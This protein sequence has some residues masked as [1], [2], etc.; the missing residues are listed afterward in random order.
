MDGN[1]LEPQFVWAS[2]FLFLFLPTAYVV[3][4]EV[5]FSLCTPFVGGGGV[6]TFQ[7]LDR[8][9][10]PTFQGGGTYL[11]RSVWGGGVI[12]LPRSTWGTYLGRGVGGYLPSQV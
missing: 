3:R 6:P 2:L 7:G 1:H 11:P 8:G 12:Y 9:G 10:V 5:I 4:E